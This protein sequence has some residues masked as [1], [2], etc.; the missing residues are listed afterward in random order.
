M[1][2]D[3]IMSEVLFYT[4]TDTEEKWIKHVSVWTNNERIEY[5]KVAHSVIE[6]DM[7]CV[8]LPLDENDAVKMDRWPIKQIVK[9]TETLKKVG[10]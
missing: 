9:V 3:D 4:E 8:I 1:L 2:A 6:G 10:N 5:P 7:Y